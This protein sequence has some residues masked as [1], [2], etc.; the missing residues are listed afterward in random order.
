MTDLSDISGEYDFLWSSCAFEH[1]G[2]LDGGLDFVVSAM[3][4]LKPGGI[5]VHTTEF[6]V[7]SNNDTLAEG[8]DC[9]YRRRDFEN[10]DY[11]LRRIGCGLD[12]IDYFA[13]TDPNDLRF[14]RAPFFQRGNVHI[15]LEIGGFVCTSILLAARKG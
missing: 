9:L 4:L 13:G 11:R 3:R 7:S 5:A 10:L 6:N 8:P 2:T 1:L 14:D 15:K 12:P